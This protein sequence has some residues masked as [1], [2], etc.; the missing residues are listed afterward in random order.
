MKLILVRHG[1]A[2]P[3]P[4]HDFTRTLTERGLA[5]AKTTASYIYE[6]YAPDACVVSPLKRA[7]Q[8]LGEFMAVASEKNIPA[9]TY[10]CDSIKP[11]DDAR[12]ALDAL[13][14]IQEK[15][16]AK[17]LLVVCHMDIIARMDTLLTGNSF[18]GF[19]LAEARVYEQALIAPDMSSHTD[20]FAPM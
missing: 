2:H 18:T 3:N 13:A 17:C 15:A 5:Q 20:G 1:E 6:K 9:P 19:S 14:T 16:D 7:Q 4:H 11:N 8:T 12:E 10:M